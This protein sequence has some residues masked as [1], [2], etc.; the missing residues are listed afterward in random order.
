MVSG[1]V[2]LRVC[3]A[4]CFGEMERNFSHRNR[5][6][7]SIPAMLEFRGTELTS[8]RRKHTCALIETSS[9]SV[10]KIQPFCPPSS[11]E[12]IPDT[13]ST[14][15]SRSVKQWNGIRWLPQF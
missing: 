7:A 12:M 1:A 6:P 11:Q 15:R 2:R 10:I 5:V 3:Q 8:I 9:A 13:T 4:Y 14:I